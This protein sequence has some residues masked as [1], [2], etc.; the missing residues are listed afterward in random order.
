LSTATFP[1]LS[2]FGYRYLGILTK[3]LG[4]LKMNSSPSGVLWKSIVA[5]NSAIKAVLS[6]A[7]LIPIYAIKLEE[8]EMKCL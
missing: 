3:A 7:I 5:P 1:L 6:I 4:F 8:N 2:K